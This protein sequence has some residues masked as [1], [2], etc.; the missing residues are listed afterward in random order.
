MKNVS[1]LV[2]KVLLMELQN[3]AV[4]IDFYWWGFK[5]LISLTK[6]KDSLYGL[7]LSDVLG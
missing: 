4:L 7:G 3:Y 2:P 6:V 5:V 1:C